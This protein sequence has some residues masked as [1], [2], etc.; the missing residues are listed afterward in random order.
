[1]SPAKWSVTVSLVTAVSWLRC[2]FHKAVV[3]LR[4]F[5]IPCPKLDSR[6]AEYVWHSNEV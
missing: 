4:K 1:M 2:Q 5:S 3:E 6:N